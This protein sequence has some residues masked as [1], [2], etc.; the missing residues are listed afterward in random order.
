[1]EAVHTV[2]FCDSS[3]CDQLTA[4]NI[5][6]ETTPSAAAVQLYGIPVPGVVGNEVVGVDGSERN[7]FFE[8]MIL[9]V[10]AQQQESTAEKIM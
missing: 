4:H 5:R 1:M 9:Q 2:L 10:C 6:N 8:L 3:G 7:R